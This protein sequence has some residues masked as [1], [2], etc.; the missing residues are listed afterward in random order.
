[1]N[2]PTEPLFRTWATSTTDSSLRRI[3]L[4]SDNDVSP[5][6]DIE[7]VC[8]RI[9]VSFSA[10]ATWVVFLLEWICPPVSTLS[11]CFSAKP[12]WAQVSVPVPNT[13]ASQHRSSVVCRWILVWVSLFYAT[14]WPF[15]FCLWTWGLVNVDVPQVW[16]HKRSK[17]IIDFTNPIAQLLSRM[18]IQIFSILIITETKDD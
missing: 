6:V 12:A 8:T 7:M 10:Y 18:W 1:M 13:F 16:T 17:L 11:K 14:I 9:L 2:A 4:S 5:Y 15:C 3:E